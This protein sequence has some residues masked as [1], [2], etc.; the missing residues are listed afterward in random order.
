MAA[1]TT[2]KRAA[3]EGAFFPEKAGKKRVRFQ[4]GSIYNYE[5]LEVLGSGSY[6]TVVKARDLRTGETVAVKW[7][8][9]GGDGVTDLR[10]VHREASCLAA[11]GGHPSVVQIRDVA[12]DE[13]T[14]DVF[15]VMEF[16]GPSLHRLVTRTRPSGFSEA[17]GCMRQLLRGAERM[18]GAGVVHRDIK[19]DNILVGEGGALK[20]CD[21]GM[22][23]PVNPAGVP[24][25]EDRVCTLWYRA[26]EL[27][28]G[29]RAYGPAVDVWSLGCVMA[30]LLAGA[31][32]FE[33]AEDEEDMFARVM[34]L[35]I[36]MAAAECRAFEGLPNLSEAGRELL[37]GLLSFEPDQRLTAKEALDHRW[38]EE[39]DEPVS[40]VLLSPKQP[41]GFINFF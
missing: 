13:A 21:L 11:C 4:F 26:P 40:S 24:Y 6:G 37:C 7:I 36:E 3:P 32:L 10:A 16:V 28:M 38:F 15:I 20:I 14:G 19:P 23:A 9:C 1:A 18:H 8:R 29:A 25:D 2:R 33:G 34:E 31:P 39:D 12:A 30:E 35:R 17:R 27:V 5:K 41:T 22:A